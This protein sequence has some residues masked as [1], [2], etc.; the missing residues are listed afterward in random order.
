V[1][2]GL[3]VFPTGLG[4]VPSPASV[5]LVST[6]RTVG[7]SFSFEPQ[8]QERSPL[9]FSVFFPALSFHG[10]GNNYLLSIRLTFDRCLS[11]VS[12]LELAER[13]VKAVP[14]DMVNPRTRGLSHSNHFF[15]KLL[16]EAPSTDINFSFLRSCFPP[17]SPY[18]LLTFSAG[19][20][21]AF[22]G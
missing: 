14:W 20:R 13:Q 8:S 9:T 18:P 10:T 4:C 12:C 19:L 6:R 11:S 7:L 21:G 22:G 17:N 1:L 2:K 15:R 3:I 5:I 16:G